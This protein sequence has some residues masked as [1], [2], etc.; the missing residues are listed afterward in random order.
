[1]SSPP[2]LVRSHVTIAG[3]RPLSGGWG[4]LVSGEFVV[5]GTPTWK[6]LH[7]IH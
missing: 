6:V 4:L 5:Y 1:V 3:Q 7:F 2:N